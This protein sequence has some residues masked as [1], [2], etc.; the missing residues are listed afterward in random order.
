[1]EEKCCKSAKKD[2][3]KVS[4]KLPK[5]STSLFLLAYHPT[6]LLHFQWQILLT[7]SGETDIICWSRPHSPPPH[8][9]SLGKLALSAHSRLGREVYT[10]AKTAHC[11]KDCSLLQSVSH[12][13]SILTSKALGSIQIPQICLLLTTLLMLVERPG[14]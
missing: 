11:C 7:A 13:L 1:M 2:T 5:F 12:L 3:V 4:R 6:N 14:R 10:A 9:S 8:L